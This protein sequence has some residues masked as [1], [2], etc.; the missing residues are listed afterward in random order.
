MGAGH[1]QTDRSSYR[2]VTALRLVADRLDGVTLGHPLRVAID[3]ITAAGKTTFANSLA[4]DLRGRGRDVER[5]SM[6]GFHHPMAV[7]YQQ[8]RSSADGY[9]EHAYD[10]AA[11]KE[12]VLDPLGPDGA[13]V[14]RTAIIDLATDQ[15]VVD[16]V[17]EVGPRAIVIVDGSFLQ[18]PEVRAGWDVVIFLRTSYEAAERRGVA[19]D[20]DHLGGEDNARLAFR[21]R[22]H[23]AQRRY[24]DECEPELA[25]DV[26]VDVEDPAEPR[27]V[28]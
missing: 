18:R 8:G 23:A 2:V 12:H 19:R 26:V 20:A 25:A 9:Y 24:I 13:G 3:G 4:D 6:D 14:V 28:R 15:P 22:Y 10:F 21:D 17:D 5:I 1:R 7:R 27:F 16:S 11:L